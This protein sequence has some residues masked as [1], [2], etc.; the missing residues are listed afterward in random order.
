MQN[1]EPKTLFIDAGN[2]FVKVAA[3]KGKRFKILKKFR[4]KELLKE[5]LPLKGV[6]KGKEV[7][8]ACV[9]PEVGEVIR[10]F[11]LKSVEVR[12]VKG[13][14]VKIEYRGEMGGDRVANI[15]GGSSLFKSFIVASFG[16]ATVVDAVVNGKFRG[17]VI[18][19]G[20]RLMGEALGKGT[21]LLPKVKE[22]KRPSLGRETVE[23]I[24]GGILKA[25]TSLVESVRNDFPGIPVL[26][27][28]GFGKL[29]SKLVKGIFIE[30]LTFMGIEE[31]LKW[32]RR[33]P[34]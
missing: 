27:T 19:P 18:T 33:L 22:F 15:L 29:V 7:A 1:T 4:T 13:L 5:P 30:E 32:G 14:P 12:A 17:G 28:G 11:S 26:I 31:F 25:T 21:S 10:E 23:C 34:L 9:V 2:T 24:E 20:L 6:V 3:K 16:T 8:F